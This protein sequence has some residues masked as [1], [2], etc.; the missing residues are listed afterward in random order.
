MKNILSPYLTLP[1]FLMTFFYLMHTICETFSPFFPSFFVEP[2]S[3]QY[4][5]FW[6]KKREKV[7]YCTCYH[8]LCLFICLYS[9]VQ[10]I[11]LYKCMCLYKKITLTFIMFYMGWNNITQFYIY[12][13]TFKIIHLHLLNTYIHTTLVQTNVD[14]F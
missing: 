7:Q 14:Q 6:E 1:S 11:K 3:L 12:N 4:V 8:M 9:F 2:T 13:Y 10:C 5:L